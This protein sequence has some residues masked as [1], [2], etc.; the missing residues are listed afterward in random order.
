MSIK[1]HNYI[2]YYQIEVTIIYDEMEELFDGY[3]DSEDV[4]YCL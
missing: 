2:F 1:V 3:R 4:T